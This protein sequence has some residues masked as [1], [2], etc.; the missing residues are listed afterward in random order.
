MYPKINGAVYAREGSAY[1]YSGGTNWDVRINLQ[2][3]TELT[4]EAGDYIE[5]ETY[6][7]RTSVGQEVTTVATDCELIVRRIA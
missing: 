1:V 6:V 7:F 5:I 4:L 3:N 2:I